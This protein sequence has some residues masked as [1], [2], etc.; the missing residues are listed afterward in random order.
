MPSVNLHN[1]I[2]A[3]FVVSCFAVQGCATPFRPYWQS[4]AVSVVADSTV[5]GTSP[6]RF[7]DLPADPCLGQQPNI[8]EE[9]EW[10]ESEVASVDRL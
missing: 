3:M 7:L 4:A 6:A 10:S 2:C 5:A 8:L 9:P 1:V